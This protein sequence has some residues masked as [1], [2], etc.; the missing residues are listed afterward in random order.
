MTL[1]ATQESGTITEDQKTDASSV[2]EQA[3]SPDVTEGAA[4][5]A[6][7]EPEAK[8]F[9]QTLRDEFLAKYGDGQEEAEAEAKP[10]PDTG[11][12][13]K[14]ATEAQK[15][16]GDEEF[17]LSDDDFKKLPD[18]VRKRIGHL[19]TRAHKAEKQVSEYAAELQ[20]TRDAQSRLDSL[21]TFVRTNGIEPEN[22][23][24]AFDMMARLAKGDHAGFLD[25]IQPFVD[26]AMQA[27]GR[28]ISPDLQSKVD[29]GYLSEE[30]ARELTASRIRAQAAEGKVQRI[31]TDQ[32][33]RETAD[34]AS[35][36]VSAIANAVNA[37][38]AEI[39]GSDPDYDSKSQ[40]VREYMERLLKRGAL[41]K[42][43]QE[44]VEFVNEAHAY[45]TAMVRPATPAVKEAPRRPNSSTPARGGAAPATVHDAIS[46]ALESYVPAASR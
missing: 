30:A 5:S 10:A 36:N 29:D 1:D 4:S 40:A 26:A 32:R 9:E 15:D 33:A 45:A 6:A 23:T 17:R 27:S 19:N 24:V 44:A 12:V 18:G 3:S 14:E 11:A 39:R 13:R 20:V 2:A 34:Q 8:T 43:P 31:T 46:G 37:R 16:D 28:A 42:S 41:P 21:Q 25:A 22:I 7:A 35:R 38:E